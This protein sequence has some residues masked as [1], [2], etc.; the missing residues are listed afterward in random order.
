M[1][2]IFLDHHSTTPP[3]EAVI[4]AVTRAMRIAGNASSSH[5]G[6]KAAAKIVED[7]RRCVAETMG[8]VD[9]ADV[10]FTSGATESNGIV[11]R[12]IVDGE[13]ERGRRPHIVT[14]AIEHSAILVPLRQL[15][16]RGQ[17]TFTAVPV[18]ASGIVNP[19]DVARAMRPDTVL[20]SVMGGQNEVGTIQPV[21]EIAA[22]AHARGVPMHSDL[23]Q[24]FGKV[25]LR[26]FDFASASSHKIYGVTGT[27]CVLIPQRFLA[28]M[29]V[30]ALGGSQQNGVRGGT[31]NLHGIAGFGAAC[32]EMRTWNA[33]PQSVGGLAGEALRLCVLRDLLLKCLR[34]ALGDEIVRV[35]GAIDAP[36]GAPQATND[37]ARRLRLPHSLSVRLVGVCPISLDAA[38]RNSIDV[39][40][41]AACKSLGGERSHV[42][43][44]MGIP[45]DGAVVRIGL[46]KC[47]NEANVRWAAKVIADAALPLVGVGC[48][49][50]EGCEGGVC[51]VRR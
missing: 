47:N 28:R 7:A 23:C 3:S 22:V 4:D 40:A 45:E 10:Y 14:S 26:G 21:E 29:S 37:P 31:L 35:N 49:A 38:V 8:G 33:G 30:P 32:R 39:S 1:T 11:L 51:P 20:V 6:G 2:T 13:N 24:S 42:L 12:S 9:P 50:P 36:I 34:D 16:R 48:D 27:G 5:E 18:G 15:A 46:G 44:A 25:P 17:C 19:A 43:E 41:A